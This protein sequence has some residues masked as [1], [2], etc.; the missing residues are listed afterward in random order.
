LYS[1]FKALDGISAEVFVVDNNSVDGSAAMIK[2]RFPQVHYIQNTKNVGF[3]AGNNQALVLA[4]GKYCLLLNPDTVVQEDTFSKTIAFMEA[5]PQAG[6]L[7]IK[8]VDGKGKFL[9]ESKRGLP[10]PAVA[11]YKIFG[12]AKFFPQSYKFGQYHLTYLDQNKNHEVEILSGAFM[13]MRK[14]ALDKAGLLDETFFMYGEDIDLSYRLLLAGYKNYYFS[15]SSIIH[16]K[17]ESTKKSS[18][19]Y[20]VVF[21]KAM[22]IFANKHFSN[23]NARLFTLLIHL[24]IYLRAA[25]AIAARFLKQLFFPAIDFLLILVGLYFCKDIYESRFKLYPNFYSKDILDFFFPIYTLLWMSFAYFNGGYDRPQSLRKLLRGVATGS[26]FILIVYSLL[27]ENYRFSRAIILIGSFYTA[28]VYVLTRLIYHAIGIK[29]FLLGG[30]KAELRLA[31]IG[32]PDEYQRVK[33][34]LLKTKIEPEFIGYISTSANNTAVPD[35]I[36]ALSQL[37][38]VV[39]V[40]KIHEVIFC[41]KDISS[42][43]IIKYMKELVASG[44]EFKIAPPESLSIIGSNSID[45]AGD[46]YV[47]DINNIGKPENRRSKRALDIILS[48][49]FIGLCWLLVWTQK[50]KRNFLLNCFKVLLGSYSW[51]GYGK[52][53]RKDL[54]SVRPSVLTPADNLPPNIGEERINRA[55]VNYSRNYSIESDLKI[56][57]NCRTKLGA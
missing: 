17:G 55:L 29:R 52:T 50:N 34:V 12:L 35:Y 5:H 19:N 9:P 26:A 54:P 11:F 56:I 15:E 24:A 39:Q 45:T 38:E 53:D 18:V 3:S 6:G 4:K 1:V 2:A 22:A 47:V 42:S 31:I 51:V 33:E 36:G 30:K 49:V 44:L 37:Q 27:Q 13:L 28:G 25:A 46:L 14:E 48:L 16:Y 40:S 7:G 21:Y 41:A 8:M 10:T 43:D 23:G 57:W 20:V 32:T